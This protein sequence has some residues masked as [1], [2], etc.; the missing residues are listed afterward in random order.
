MLDLVF[1]AALQTQLGMSTSAERK[2][3]VLSYLAQLGVMQ[4][5]DAPS[6]ETR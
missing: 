2:A 4:R 6:K 5:A 1:I 3:Q